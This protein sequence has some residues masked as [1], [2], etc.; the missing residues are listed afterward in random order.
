MIAT[1]L[2][3]YNSYFATATA[4]ATIERCVASAG[5]GRAVATETARTVA[6][7][8]R[9]VAS[10]TI[11]RTIEIALGTTIAIAIILYRSTVGGWL[12]AGM[13]AGVASNSPPRVH[14]HTSVGGA[15][16]SWLAG[17]AERDNPASSPAQVWLV[18]FFLVYGGVW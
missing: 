5:R 2:L 12:R 13:G 4:T 1:L 10:V 8:E 6:I 3:L 17:V 14:G 15:G 16:E 7:I 11:G 18:F 9:C